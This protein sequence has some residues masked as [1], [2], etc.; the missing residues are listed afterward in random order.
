M[1]AL[2]ETNSQDTTD[3]SVQH[4]LAKGKNPQSNLANY[5]ADMDVVNVHKKDK[6]VSPGSWENF[7]LHC[8]QCFPEKKEVAEQ[9][10]SK[11]SLQCMLC[12]FN[13]TTVKPRH[14][15]SLHCKF[16]IT[17]DE[18]DTADKT[19]PLIQRMTRLLKTRSILIHLLTRLVKTS[20]TMG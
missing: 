11:T 1:A 6:L 12:P 9:P 14:Y 2:P 3:L 7:C 17:V 15:K 10:S 18:T 19:S 13:T 4:L 5:K 16:D 20:L 8:N